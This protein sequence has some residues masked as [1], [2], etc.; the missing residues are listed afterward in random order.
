[1]GMSEYYSVHDKC[2][3]CNSTKFLHGDGHGIRV[4]HEFES[5]RKSKPRHEKRRAVL[6]DWNIVRRYTSGLSHVLEG[7]VFGHESFPEGA[8]ITT[9]PVLRL[10]IPERTAETLN[11]VYLLG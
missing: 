10:D 7:Q 8:F 9:S 2:K 5:P 4:A 6:K 11:T 1:M 3:V